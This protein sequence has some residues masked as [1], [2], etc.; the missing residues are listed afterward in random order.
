MPDLRRPKGAASERKT[1]S[2]YREE[3]RE[4]E[5]RCATHIFTAKLPQFPARGWGKKA[6]IAGSKKSERG[7]GKATRRTSSWKDIGE[8]LKESGQKRRPN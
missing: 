8:P 3:K 2:E 6:A 5:T 1:D 4:R 7:G